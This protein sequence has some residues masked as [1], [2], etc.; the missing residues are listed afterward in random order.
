MRRPLELLDDCRERYGDA[1]TLRVARF[2][3]FVLTSDPGEIRALF[4]ADRENEL[5]P[6]R[7]AMLE[8]V[9]GPRSVLLQQGAEHMRRRK[10][11]LPPFHGERM[12]AYEDLITE[13]SE[14]EVESWPAGETIRLH[15]RFQALTLEVILAAIFGVAEGERADRLRVLLGEVLHMTSSPAT[16][17]VGVFAQRF[18]RFGPWRRFFGMI[19]EID[20]LLAREIAERREDPVLAE[21]EDI[22]SMLAAA[23]FDDGSRMDDA[24]I[25]DQLMTLLLAGHETTATALA[26]TFDLLFRSPGAWDRLR[27]EVRSPGDGRDYTDAVAKEGLRMRPV[28]PMV[29]RRIASPTEIGGFEVPAGTDVFPAIHLVHMREDLYDQPREFR[30]ERWLADDVPSFAWIPFGGGTRRCLGAAF[31][32]FEMRI[33]LQTVV[34][35]VELEPAATRP[36]RVVRRNITLSPGGGTPALVGGVVS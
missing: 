2:P 33:V 5:P 28:I 23:E 25:R 14:R 7:A 36:E 18:R 8:P 13:I 16:M 4:G 27:D 31:A 32:Q 1:F 11:M 19:A 6:G 3:P 35:R 30:P 24:E 29:G 9:M 21:R 22:L 15:P 26:W 20:E 17:A 34:G 12:R 10:L